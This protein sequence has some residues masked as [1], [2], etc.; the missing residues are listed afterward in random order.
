[1][2][3][4]DAIAVK[5]RDG[6][7]RNKPFRV[8]VGVARGRDILGIWVGA[9][10]EDAKLWLGVFT[11]LKNRGVEDVCIVVC[12]GLR[13][14]PESITTTWEFAVVKTSIVHL[15]RNTFRFALRKYWDQITRDPR[16]VYTAPFEA[17]ARARFEKLTEEWRT[18]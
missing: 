11:E 13:G 18:M 16:P 12:D 5:V 4:I 10:G 6:Q 1:M 9:G 2:V 14:L 15:I 8:A 17:G 7:V 3:F